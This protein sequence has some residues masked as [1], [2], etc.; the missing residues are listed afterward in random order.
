M[1]VHYVGE[2][3]PD[4]ARSLLFITG[5][6][7]TW[8]KTDPVSETALCSFPVSDAGQSPEHSRQ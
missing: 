1:E 8:V 3:L 5:N 7:I 4:C 6:I 2:L